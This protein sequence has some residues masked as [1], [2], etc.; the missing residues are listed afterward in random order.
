M[1]EKTPGQILWERIEGPNWD[2][3]LTPEITRERFESVAMMTVEPLLERIAELEADNR[4]LAGAIHSALGN[5]APCDV[6]IVGG[7]GAGGTGG[8][9][10]SAR[11][12][13]ELESLICTCPTIDELKAVGSSCP[14][15]GA[16]NADW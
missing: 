13:A 11:R 3:P 16:R 7:G 6:A 2:S 4:R 9:L 8:V 10:D 1:S 14:T 5:G 12:I 15:H